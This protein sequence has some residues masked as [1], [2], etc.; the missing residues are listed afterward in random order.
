MLTATGG[1]S[2]STHFAASRNGPGPIVEAYLNCHRNAM[3]VGAT[4]VLPPKHQVEGLS[5]ALREGGNNP[6]LFE[7]AAVVVGT[8]R[9]ASKGDTFC[10]PE[11]GIIQCLAHAVLCRLGKSREQQAAGDR[12]CGI[13]ARLVD[14]LVVPE[15]SQ[16]TSNPGM[17]FLSMMNKRVQDLLDEHKASVAEMESS[18]VASDDNPEE[19]NSSALPSGGAM[20]VEKKKAKPKDRAKP[21]WEEDSKEFSS[22]GGDVDDL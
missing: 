20:T 19:G 11:E 22:D 1:A 2:A 14:T 4:N 6:A 16:T 15:G 5:Q 10:E 9:T 21:V 12:I 17:E 7:L 13:A 3:P 18:K 8:Y